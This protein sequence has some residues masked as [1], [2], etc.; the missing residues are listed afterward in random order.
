MKKEMQH[1]TRNLLQQSPEA[2]V[3]IPAEGSKTLVAAF[4]EYGVQIPTPR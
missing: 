2:F 1:Y 4:T 3:K